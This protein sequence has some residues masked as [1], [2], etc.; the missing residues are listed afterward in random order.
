MLAL[1][2]GSN[3]GAYRHSPYLGRLTT[4]QCGTVVGCGLPWAADNGAFAGFDEAAYLRMLDHL[5]PGGLFVVAPD[6]VADHAATLELWRAWSPKLRARGFTPAFVL[7]D[8]CAE[9]PTDAEALFI[10][11]STAYKL[12]ATAAR[13]ARRHP[14]W[15]HMGRV[16]SKRRVLYAASIGCDSVDGTAVS[17][18]PDTKLPLMLRWCEQASRQG[19][20]L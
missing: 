19:V 14:G 20:L 11:G 13:I 12:G 9:A 7:Q 1:V 18:F 8:G 16:N 17:M 10:G 6:V 5:P 4:P 3:V 15:V 2:S